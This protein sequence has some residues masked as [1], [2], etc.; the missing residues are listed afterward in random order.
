MKNK[1]TNTILWWITW[2]VLTIVSF[3]IACAFWTP[4]IAKYVGSMDKPGTSIIWVAAVFGS[5][6]VLLV[7]LIVIMYNKVDKAYEDA[8]IARET[9]AYEKKK[10]LFKA[11]VVYVDESKR[12]LDKK[13][14]KKIKNFPRAIQQGHL[15]DVTL[16]DGQRIPYVF[17]S[18]GDE[19]LGVYGAD[20]LSF[21][22]KD[23]VDASASNLD[24]LPIFETTKWLR[25]DG[26]GE[27]RL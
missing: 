27:I 7:P 24:T 2:I 14:S 1:D 19:I 13:I 15:V 17:I 12:L 6:M 26:A 20:Q 11:K 3:F 9:T 23:V 8:R 16:R 4:I 18:N 21:T 25:L 10:N 22:A 5:W